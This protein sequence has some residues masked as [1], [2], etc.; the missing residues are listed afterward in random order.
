MREIDPSIKLAINE[1]IS[2]M[3]FSEKQVESIEKAVVN[4]LSRE[5]KPMMVI[6]ERHSTILYLLGAMLGIMIPI[7]FQLY[8]TNGN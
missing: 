8:T 3:T 1:A 2:E 6:Q 7:V 4:V 5:L